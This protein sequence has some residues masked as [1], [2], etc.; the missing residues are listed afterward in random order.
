MDYLSRLEQGGLIS[1]GAVNIAENQRDPPN[2]GIFG[3]RGGQGRGRV[4]REDSAPQSQGHVERMWDED[5]QRF[6]YWDGSQWQWQ[7]Q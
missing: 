3:Q 1:S 6:R 7:Q 5:H 4:A 2:H